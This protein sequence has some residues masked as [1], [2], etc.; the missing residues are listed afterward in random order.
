MVLISEQTFR[1]HLDL[2]YQSPSTDKWYQSSQ[3][4][5]LIQ[6]AGNYIRLVRKLQESDEAGRL[7]GEHHY[8][9]QY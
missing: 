7:R 2:I 9:L 5:E 8:S 1:Q 6:L 4:V 3:V